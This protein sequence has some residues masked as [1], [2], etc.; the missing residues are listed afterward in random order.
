MAQQV[1]VYDEAIRSITVP[2]DS[3]IGFFTGVA[4][5]LGSPVTL[6]TPA[7][8]AIVTAG[9]AGATHY[10]YRVSALSA[11]GETLASAEATV[12]TGNAAL[13]AANSNTVSWAPVPGAVSYNIYGRLPGAG[14]LLGN[15]DTLSFKDDG[16]AVPGSAPPIHN[17]SGVNS[18][19]QYHFVKMTALQRCGLARGVED[20][21][22]DGVLYNKPQHEGMAATVVI[23]GVAVVASGDT[24]DGDELI[25]V[26][27]DGRAVVAPPGT[28]RSAIAAKA[29]SP[30]SPGELM[31]ALLKL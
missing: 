21:I 1:Q 5:A 30:S 23:R 17:L 14:Q 3:S 25:M 2:A 6:Q 26:G 11:S 12:L 15:T 9:A 29:M 19:K 7:G 8:V 22:V 16:S 4:G 10:A 27:P 31:S 13:S 28:P 18:G 24:F 20:E